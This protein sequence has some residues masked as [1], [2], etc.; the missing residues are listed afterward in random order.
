MYTLKYS[1]FCYFL[2]DKDH[3]IELA[4]Q[5][6]RIQLEQERQQQIQLT[7]DIEMLNVQ[8]IESKNGLLAAARITDQLENYQLANINLKDERKYLNKI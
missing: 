6:L 3:D 4:T 7:K 1:D 8:L 2:L 5:K